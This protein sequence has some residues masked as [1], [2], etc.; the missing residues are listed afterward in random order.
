MFEAERDRLVADIASG[1]VAQRQ[2][3]IQTTIA[4]LLIAKRNNDSRG[5]FKR[6]IAEIPST[7]ITPQPVRDTA[8]GLLI[9]LG[10]GLAAAFLRDYYD[11]A[12]RTKEDLDRITG[13]VPVLGIIPAVKLWRNEKTALL[14]SIAHPNSAASEAYRSLRTA[15][16]FTG[17]GKDM[18]LIHVTSSTA[19]EGKSTTAANLAVSLARAGHDV[20]LVDC[21]LRRPR[22]HKFFGLENTVGFTTVMLGSTSIEQALQRVLDVPGL[23]LL[24]SGPQPPNPSE[25][26][27]SEVAH[28]RIDLLARSADYVVI[29]SPPLLPVSDSVILAG[30]AQATLLVARARSANRR[31]IHRSLELLEQ[32]DGHLAGVVLNGVGTEGTYGYGYGYVSD[33]PAFKEKVV[34]QHRRSRLA[35]S[36]LNGHGPAGPSETDGADDESAL[37]PATEPTPGDR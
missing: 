37:E 23:F 20:V 17:V 19:G 31:D 6:S 2:V 36:E 8:I 21:D 29:D 30:Y 22:A 34:S 11:D 12:V 3:D 9:G 28:S 33:D 1:S 26:L 13:G 15:L 10:L 14:E 32:V 4:K 18:G 25:L 5:I 24:S 35:S 27:A 16:E 7:P